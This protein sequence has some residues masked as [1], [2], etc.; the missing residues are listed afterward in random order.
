MTRQ[1]TFDERMEIYLVF[2]NAVAA[3]DAAAW[4]RIIARCDA[5][6]EA[7]ILPMF[8]RARLSAV[9]HRIP[10][11]RMHSFAPISFR[12]FAGVLSGAL[13][14]LQTS[15]F[16]TYELSQQIP[17]LR[18]GKRVP[19][20]KST[21]NARLDRYI[22]ADIEVEIALS[23]HAS[24]SPTAMAAV[25]AAGAAVLRHGFLSDADFARSYFAIAPE[26]SFV[27]L[28]SRVT[29]ERYV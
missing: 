27:E 13:E 4:Q 22:D 15:I 6:D 20:S 19:R 25:R 14:V 7:A 29:P 18:D 16:L 5:F 10:T 8:E 11:S 17:A 2:A 9:P 23:E 1:Q 26:I 28:E 24:S 21:G 12:V 3:F